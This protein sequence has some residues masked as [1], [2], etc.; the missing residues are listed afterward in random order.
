MNTSA[1]WCLHSGVSINNTCGRNAL[2]GTSFCAEHAAVRVPW[3]AF[4][5]NDWNGLAGAE[6]FPDGSDPFI[7]EITV[8]GHVGFA[9]HDASGLGLFWYVDY[10]EYTAHAKTAAVPL[11]SARTTLT[12]LRGL[13]GFVLDPF[14]DSVNGPLVG[15]DA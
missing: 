7:A 13:P 8:D 5:Q 15:G 1:P 10:K 14:A 4:T 2:P 6:P 9:V 11:L 12:A 3:R